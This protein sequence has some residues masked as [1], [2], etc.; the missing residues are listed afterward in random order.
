MK[1]IGLA[2]AV[3]AASLAF[4]PVTQAQQLEGFSDQETA[5]VHRGL[6]LA[7]A[8]S[9]LVTGTL[10]TILAMNKPT[11]FGEGL[12][13]EGEPIF[14]SYGCH[15]LS[16]LHGVSAVLTLLL[17]TTTTT[18]EFAEGTWPG[19]GNH[20]DGYVVASAITMGA[21]GALPIV[22]FIAAVPAFLGLPEGD[23]QKVLRTLHLSV[24]YLAVGTYITTVALD[25]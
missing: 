19:S 14:G 11:L 9:M 1:T 15:G 8:G 6:Q 20:N 12:C 17:Y 16:V 24:A 21:M 13:A 2:I 10:G 7:T 25:L 5:D 22:G 3:A 23:F 18:L 4:T